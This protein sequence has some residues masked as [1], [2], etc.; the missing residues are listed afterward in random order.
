MLILDEPTRGIDVGAKQEIYQLI[1][2][3]SE[4]GLGII[5]ISS[6]MDE[7]LGMSD[8]LLVMCEGKITGAIDKTEFSQ[9]LVLS[10]A[11]G[12]TMEGR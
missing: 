2:T 9:E 4:Q 11:S 8:R 7:I 5:V 6:E 3:L 12:E 10:Y 1:N